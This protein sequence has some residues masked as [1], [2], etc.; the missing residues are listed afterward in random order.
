[1]QLGNRRQEPSTESGPDRR[2]HHHRHEPSAESRSGHRKHHHRHKTSTRSRPDNHKNHRQRQPSVE[3]DSDERLPL[4]AAEHR[5]RSSAH[6]RSDSRRSDNG[7]EDKARALVPY[8][9]DAADRS[10][11]EEDSHRR[12]R[13]RR[14]GNK[15]RAQRN[16]SQ[17]ERERDH[18]LRNLM[19]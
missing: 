1:M 2:K 13:T 17:G 11:D 16:P 10:F 19:R 15:D 3:S 9:G 4:P 8:Q 14:A 18:R 6:S 5:H 7:S 12:D